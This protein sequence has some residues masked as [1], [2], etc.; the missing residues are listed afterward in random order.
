MNGNVTLAVFGAGRSTA[1]KSLYQYDYGQV[2]QITGLSLPSAY[3]VHFGNAAEGGVTKTSI[4]GPDGVVIPDEYLTSGEDIWAFVYLH[5][6]E[7]DG[8]TEYVVHIPVRKRPEPSDIEPTPEQQ[9]V[10]TQT[11]AALNVAV[12]K[13]ENAVEHYPY[14]GVDGFWYVWDAQA[15]TF[16]KSSKAQGDKGNPGDK[17]DTGDDGVSP[18]ATTDSVNLGTL[19]TITDASGAHQFLVQNGAK[20]NKGDDGFSPIVTKP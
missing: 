7:D 1:T 18:T 3:E 15:E 8:E 19:V 4:G 17:G 12:D 11:I 9:D 2:L 13:A 6:G 5:T 20:G 14:I 10:I 16:V